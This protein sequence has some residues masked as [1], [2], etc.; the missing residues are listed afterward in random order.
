[1]DWSLVALAEMWRWRWRLGLPAVIG[2]LLG[3][4]YTLVCPPMYEAFAKLQLQSE[5]AREPLLQKITAAGHGDALYQKLIAPD[6][7]GDTGRELGVTVTPAHVRL[8]VLNDHLL[9]IRYSSPD[10][11]NLEHL[12]DSLAYNFIQQVL[13][14][15]RARI[16]Q[17]LSES[18]QN[19]SEVVRQQAVS[20]TL[21]DQGLPITTDD[22]ATLALKR[23]QLENDIIQLQTDLRLVNTAFERNGSQALLW[24]A[25]PAVLVPP[26]STA[27]RL[28]L[29][30]ILGGI[31]GYGA[32]WMLLV[33][34]RRLRKGLVSQATTAALTGLPLAGTLPWLGKVRIDAH[35]AQVQTHGKTLRPAGFSEIS[36][37]QSALVRALRGPLVLASVS[38]DEG[39]SLAALLLAEKT[40]SQGKSVA[41]VDLNLKNR[42]LTRQLKMTDHDDW[43][44]PRG[45][46][47]WKALQAVDGVENLWFLPA[48]RN[49]ETLQTLAELNGL[50]RLM[51]VLKDQVD[52]V[53]VDVSPITAYNRSN[54][55]PTAVAGLSGRTVLLAQD[56][57]TIAQ[58]L[59]RAAD[60][61][62]LAG[63]PLQGILLNQQFYPTRRQL[64]GQVAD[65]LGA[66]PPLGNA[67]RKAALK[68]RV[69]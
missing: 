68:A 66:I 17:L 63:A 29:M 10:R 15:E 40:A 6:V 57:Q 62:L 12:T 54:V 14:P 3:G 53:I 27:A 11:A 30:L 46:A 5:Q 45:K 51:D 23:Q 33:A 8:T 48:P 47:E 67:L 24:F 61:L 1:M 16:E 65:A 21:G 37:L 41:L 49:S 4:G 42:A 58:D 22:P 52:V 38:G 44:L 20:S 56:H 19:L 25:Q 2:A 34:P 35:G 32:G 13:A 7:L 59:K 64:L 26:P 31:L 18:Q 69:D 28:P 60:A 9:E 36:R 50:A 55:D 43:K 39:A